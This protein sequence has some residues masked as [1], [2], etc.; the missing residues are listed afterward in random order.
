GLAGGAGPRAGQGQGRRDRHAAG[1]Q[2]RRGDPVRRGDAPGRGEVGPAGQLP[3]GA[4]VAAPTGNPPPAARATP[5]ATMS[6]ST[7]PQPDSGRRLPPMPPDSMRNIRNFSIIAHVDHGKSTL[8]DRIIQLCGGL[9]AR[10]MEAQVLDNNP[11]E[12]E[13]GITIKAQSVSLPY[14]ARDGQTYFLNFID[15]PG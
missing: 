8:A 15:T 1:P 3:V 7:P 2:P 13:R 12:R 4:A 5:C 9:T 14:T 10:E 11:I 6:R